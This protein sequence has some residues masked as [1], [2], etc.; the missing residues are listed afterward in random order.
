GFT[1]NFRTRVL[2]WSRG[3]C[4]TPL[5][6]P[7]PQGPR[8]GGREVA[9]SRTSNP[10][11]HR[12]SWPVGVV[13]EMTDPFLTFERGLEIDRSHGRLRLRQVVVMPHSDRNAVT[14]G[15]TQVPFA[16]HDRADAVEDH[17]VLVAIVVV[18]IDAGILRIGHGV[19][20]DLARA[21][22]VS[23]KHPAP[24]EL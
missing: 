24:T 2:A 4:V 8:K 12:L 7:P 3:W 20:L 1:A 16:D 10:L 22:G 9:A 15:H 13:P 17:P 21:V 23:L 5:P 11:R 19:A 6:G 18:G 14:G